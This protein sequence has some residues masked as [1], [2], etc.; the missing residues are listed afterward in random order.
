MG[1]K[2]NLKQCAVFADLTSGEMEK[3]AGLTQAKE[4]EAGA[5]IFRQMDPAG[6]IFVLEEGK[7]ALQVACANSPGR[8]ATVDIATAGELLNWT[9][10]FES[11]LHDATATCLQKSRVLAI[12]AGGLR[13]LLGENNHSCA[14]IM[15]AVVRLAMAKLNDTRQVLISERSWVPDLKQG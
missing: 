6:E 7:V 10:L 11:R 5:V 15:R 9:P 12:D 1:K 8:K 13:Q 4:Y 14:A 2:H 3:V